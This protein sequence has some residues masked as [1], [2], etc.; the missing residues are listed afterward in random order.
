MQSS[1][2]RGRRHDRLRALVKACT[3]AACTECKRNNSADRRALT[4]TGPELL[5]N[6][7]GTRPCRRKTSGLEA[8]GRTMTSLATAGSHGR[9]WGGRGRPARSQSGVCAGDL[10]ATRI[11]GCHRGQSRARGGTG[12]GDRRG[13]GDTAAAAGST[14]MSSRRGRGWPWWRARACSR[15]EDWRD[16][17]RAR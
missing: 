9:A 16:C 3:A 6:S 15:G 1:T 13:R 17:S 11:R 7:T 4:C 12:L 2:T 10:E 14:A 5:S 8:R